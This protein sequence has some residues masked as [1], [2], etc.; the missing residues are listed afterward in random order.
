[1]SVQFGISNFNG[2]P[3]ASDAI[4]RAERLLTPYA[5]DG[6]TRIHRESAA[7]L[8]GSFE[9]ALVPSATQP[10][11][12]PN[13]DWMLWDGRLDN[14]EEL[15]DRSHDLD[16][17]S[18]A[19][20]IAAG[21]YGC[22]GCEVFSELV[23]DWAV[24]V[25]S[26]DRREVILARDFIGARPLFYRTDH[27]SV[28]WSTVLE[29]LVFFGSR[30]LALSEDY[31]A[32]WLSS[33]PASELTP[34]EGILSVPPSCAIRIRMGN[35]RIHKYW[36][37]DPGQRVR[38]RNDQEY[39][40]QFRTVF[41]RAVRRRLASQAPILAELS[42][43]MDSSSI[44]CAADALIAQGECQ[45]PGVD[46]VTYFDAEEPNWDELP[47]A[48]IVEQKRGRAGTHI[49]VG[50]KSFEESPNHDRFR[51]VPSSP[52]TGSSAANCFSR[53]LSS[54]GYRVV[55]SGLGGDEI[56]GGVPTPV[57]ELAD[58][59]R[60][61][62][63][64]RF[65]RQSFAWAL[66]KR[67]PIV[68]LWGSVLRQFIPESPFWSRPARIQLTWLAPNFAARHQR[69]LDFRFRR[70][71]ITGG[72]PSFQANLQA[73]A[74]LRSQL[75]SMALESSPAY[76]WRYPYLDRD[77]MSF[78]FSIPREQLVRPRER[79]SLMR[80][81]LRDMVPRDILD[82][83]RKAYVS[84]GL[85]KV[86]CVEYTRLRNSGPLHME[87]EGI[88]DSQKLSLAVR[89]AEQGLD[90]ATVPLLRTLALEGWLRNLRQKENEWRTYVS[91][92]TSEIQVAGYGNRE[93]LGRET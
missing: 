10:Y 40:E 17:S 67:K 76:E 64:R 15:I 89:S 25:Y 42:G 83:R 5:P 35:I 28:V 13:R 12:L 11:L 23:G 19:V 29:P 65:L 69:E 43:G 75:S 30:T 84:R 38:C 21:R 3:V 63:V 53:L 52:Y 33:V 16:E 92:K 54:G 47:Y 31:F 20:E 14:R 79:R 41:R 44:V 70:I 88:V 57:P 74:S 18:S 1:M 37:F 62:E 4:E 32:G 71:S 34:Y 93:L 39:E 80:R 50:S 24:S 87:E 68:G 81:A 66:V 8:Y 46:T 91:Q 9:T 36:N 72:H 58:L 49:D 59:L 55:L 45:S 82:R 85:V 26:E 2:A 56:L 86:I 51:A 90:V 61:L 77:L 7:L 48:R 22:S 60:S 27:D 6:I 78:C 73:V